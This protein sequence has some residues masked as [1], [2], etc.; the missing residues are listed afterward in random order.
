L[1]KG[2]R[3][4]VKDEG[5]VLAVV[6]GAPAAASWPDSTLLVVLLAAFSRPELYASRM[7]ASAPQAIKPGTDMMAMEAAMWGSLSAVEL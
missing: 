7:E 1:R 4:P 3:G 6:G 2:I 5:A